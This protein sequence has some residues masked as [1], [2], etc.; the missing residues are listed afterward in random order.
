MKL[1]S[2]FKKPRVRQALLGCTNVYFN[3]SGYSSS[4]RS[5]ALGKTASTRYNFCIHILAIEKFILKNLATFRI[6]L[7]APTE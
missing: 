6:A 3:T 2:I 7:L 1:S 4:R 5:V